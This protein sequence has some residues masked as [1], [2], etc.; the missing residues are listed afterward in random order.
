MTKI[1]FKSDSEREFWMACF[2]RALT[3]DGRANATMYADRAI[4]MLREREPKNAKEPTK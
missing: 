3:G 1:T 2:C 4:T